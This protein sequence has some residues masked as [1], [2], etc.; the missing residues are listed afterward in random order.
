[1]DD[2][3]QYASDPAVAEHVAWN[4]H[5]DRVESEAFVQSCVEAI[6]SGPWYPLAITHRE[7][8]RV[9]GAIDLRIV[10]AG[11]RLGEIGYVLARPFWGQGLNV[12]AGQLILTLGFDQCG[13]NRIQAIC[14]IE[15]RRSYRTLEK[16][17]MTR[18]G[19]LR[20]YRIE[21][22]VPRDKYIYAILQKDRVTP[23]AL[24][25]CAGN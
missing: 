4:A 6:T 22:G 25:A 19:L 18:E 1:V 9:I 8:G 7:T 17:G 11:H 15:N 2:V 20:Q 16:L 10:A 13:L 5:R 14:S 21:K 24:E 3:F 12:E 23:E